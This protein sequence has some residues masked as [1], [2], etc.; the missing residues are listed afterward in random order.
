MTEVTTIVEITHRLRIAIRH[1]S[2]EIDEPVGEV[3]LE[4]S[5]PFTS[6]REGERLRIMGLE[7][8]SESRLTDSRVTKV[9]H[10]LSSERGHLTHDV[11]VYAKQDRGP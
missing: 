9:L 1:W 10:S 2:S 8:F 7:G 11:T 4:S 5:M 3:I 6:I